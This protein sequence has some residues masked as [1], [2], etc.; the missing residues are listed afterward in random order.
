MN[1]LLLAKGGKQ[2][3]PLRGVPDGW[4]HLQE[5]AEARV[6]KEEDED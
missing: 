5:R 4:V 3:L 2:R 6:V 1:P